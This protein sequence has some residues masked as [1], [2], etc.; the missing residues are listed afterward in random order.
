MDTAR[1][2]ILFSVIIC[3]LFTL[4]VLHRF[5]PRPTGAETNVSNTDSGPV[6]QTTWMPD[7]VKKTRKESIP[8]KGFDFSGVQLSPLPPCAFSMPSEEMTEECFRSFG[9]TICE[10]SSSLPGGGR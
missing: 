2:Y 4:T 5:T 8:G 7:P 6:V 3:M 10:D 9:K 1:W